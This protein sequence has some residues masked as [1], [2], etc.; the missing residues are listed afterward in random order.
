MSVW[1]ALIRRSSR[2]RRWLGLTAAI[3]ITMTLTAGSASATVGERERVFKNPYE[4]TAW[5]CGYP[6]QVVGV[7]TH[8]IHVR[9][10]RRV[11]GNVFFTN[12]Y[13]WRETWTAADGRSFTISGNGI[14]K[15]V[16]AKS[17]GGSLYQ[18]AFH[19]N[20]QPFVLKDSSGKVISRDRG[21]LTGSY[22]FDFGTGE[23]NFLG[24][25][26]HGPHPMFDVD[27]CKAV[28]PLTGISDSAK[29]LTERPIGSTD[30]PAG[31]DE[32]LP[33][34][35]TATGAQSPLLLF[36]HGYGETGDGTP[37]AISR[38]VAA[39][40]PK[41]INVG[42]WPTDRPFV[43]LAP[44]HVEDPPGFDFS[45]CDGAQFGGSCNMQVQHDNGNVQPAFCTTPN[46]VRDFIDFATTHYNV[47][48][49]RV[50]ITGLSCGAFGVWEY[51]GF[52][53]GDH[54]VAAA[55]PIAGEGRPAFATASCSLGDTPI[56]AFTGLLED[57][58]DPQGSIVPMTALQDDC[59]VPAERAK[60]TVYPDRDHNSWDPAY[61]GANGD[62]I[63][64]WMLG[65]TSP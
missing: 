19:E 49:S 23:F 44:Q 39:G 21:N 55:V 16:Q 38:L 10:D 24:N 35:Y 17:L 31:Y 53:G 47:D 1:D 6:M 50:Y 11:D 61:G 34:S 25:E 32:Y 20:G 5:D 33:P 57:T 3:V 60:L 42:G 22:T 56:W 64:S 40:I 54:K 43:V 63:Y 58:V 30:S 4:F 14:F 27:L 26:L 46:E 59:G 51:L 36:F 28:E 65:F 12:N 15:D 2:T 7:E 37:E 41:Y 48:P 18:F 45:S 52:Y 9:T 8:F 13:S 29:Y 62:D